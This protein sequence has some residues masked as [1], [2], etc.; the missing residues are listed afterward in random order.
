MTQ[1]R[2]TELMTGQTFDQ[3]SAP[4]DRSSEPGR[5]GGPKG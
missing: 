3:E 4:H 1:T 5:A 2:L